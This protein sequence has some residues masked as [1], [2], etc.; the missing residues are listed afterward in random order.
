MNSALSALTRCGSVEALRS[1]LH[2]LCDHLGPVSR[3]DVLPTIESGK[4]AAV[5][6]LRPESE[7]LEQ[8]LMAEF[9]MRRYGNDLFF[10]VD[11][12]I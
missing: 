6:F 9:G 1:T 7:A 5:C 4:S 10:I 3:L 2:S 8:L 11:L 12:K